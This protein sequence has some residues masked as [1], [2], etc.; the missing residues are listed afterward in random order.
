MTRG[1]RAWPQGYYEVDNQ[2]APMTVSTTI[3]GLVSENQGCL[4]RWS[5]TVGLVVGLPLGGPMQAS[6]ARGAFMLV[7]GER[8]QGDA[9]PPRTGRGMPGDHDMPRSNDPSLGQPDRLNYLQPPPQP[10]TTQCAPIGVVRPLTR[11]VPEHG[12]KPTLKTTVVSP[13]PPTPPHHTPRMIHGAHVWRAMTMGEAR[14]GATKLGKAG[15]T[16]QP[17]ERS[18]ALLAREAQVDGATA[19]RRK[20]GLG[21][22]HRPRAN[23]PLTHPNRGDL[24]NKTGPGNEPTL[25]PQVMSKRYPSECMLGI[26]IGPSAGARIQV[27]AS[28]EC[29]GP[30]RC[31]GGPQCRSEARACSRPTQLLCAVG[32]DP[33]ECI[34]TTPAEA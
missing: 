31:F 25:T 34:R 9:G 26:T 14:R 29:D 1:Q 4:R 20:H 27:F 10:F 21:I 8:Q 17:T 18:Q 22:H 15:A 2:T 12:R 5:I 11:R 28:T 32:R 13:P 3:G 30:R 24:A 33:Y 7:A 19:D 23:L 16:P 6:C